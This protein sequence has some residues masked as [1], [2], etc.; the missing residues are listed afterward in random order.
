MFNPSY[1]VNLTFLATL[2]GFVAMRVGDWLGGSVV[3]A[4]GMRVLNLAEEPTRRAVT[5]G[6]SEKEAAEGP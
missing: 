2:S 3:Y 1:L 4:H 5:P 6:H